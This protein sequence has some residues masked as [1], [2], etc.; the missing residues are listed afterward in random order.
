MFS[1]LK[2]V[3]ALSRKASKKE[4]PEVLSYAMAVSKVK[5]R[6]V[7][8]GEKLE[9]D[10]DADRGPKLTPLKKKEKMKQNVVKVKTE[11]DISMTFT[12]QELVEE[13]GYT[14]D[15]LESD[16]SVDSLSEDEDE[17]LKN[18][19]EMEKVEEEMNDEDNLLPGEIK[20]N[21]DVIND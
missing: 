1:R 15:Q 4:K 3:N 11:T 8:L 19:D 12:D 17:D 13:G 18:D 14:R 5:Y 7:K 6:W 2:Y 20:C 9:G 16:S 10:S 21:T